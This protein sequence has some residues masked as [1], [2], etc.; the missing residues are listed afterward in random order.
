[1]PIPWASTLDW[2]LD[3]RA[4]HANDLSAAQ[5]ANAAQLGLD[6]PR[7]LELQ[8]LGTAGFALRYQGFAVLIDP[9]LS[10]LA[11]PTLLHGRALAPDGAQLARHVP[12]ADAVLVGH[13]HFDHVL[14]IP[15]LARTHACPVYGS[16]SL[17]NLMRLHGLPDHA[18]EVVPG[19][20]YELGPFEVTFIESLHSKLL[21]GLKVPSDGEL[22][23]DHLDDLRGDRYRCGQV[24]G[25]HVRV[26]GV[27]FYHQGSANVIEER[28]QHRQVDYFL[29]G[30]AG[31]GFTRN[32]TAR[33]LR[34][35]S[36]RVVIPHH[37]DNFFLPVEGELGF[38]LNVNLG[39]FFEE[40]ER[41]SK[42][43][44]V[45]TLNPLQSIAG[46]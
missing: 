14:D 33:V 32:Y 17:A 29:A 28:I 10:R 31:R 20:V 6:L 18:V 11:L 19:R 40:V 43:F 21:L 41:V 44:R 22:T 37:Y 15:W 45:R 25:I 26:A 30:I 3:P 4:R 35:L 24:Y 12:R 27:T 42:D 39:G 9:Y 5:A 36:P 16:R 38:S 1:M 13:T 2:L 8:W 7:G 34:A 46:A 23:C